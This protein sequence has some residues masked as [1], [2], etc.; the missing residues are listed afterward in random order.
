[1]ERRVRD[2]ARA[3][4]SLM[5]LMG[6]FPDGLVFRGGSARGGSC[7]AGDTGELGLIPRLGRSPGEENGNP[8]STLAWRISW[9]EEPDG[10]QSMESQGAGHD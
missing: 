5:R 7:N 1:M 3:E 4:P 10:L 2:V 9:T 8:L 6:S